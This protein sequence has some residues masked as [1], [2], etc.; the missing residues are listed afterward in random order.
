MTE[1]TGVV[2]MF[3]DPLTLMGSAVVVGQKAPPFKALND[4]LKPRGLEDYAGKVLL[5]VAVP[6]LDTQVCDMEARRF[7]AEAA[8]LGAGVTVLVISMDLP[9]AQK[10]FCAAAEADHVIMLS[11]HRD[12]SFGINWG[13]LIKDLRLL[14]RS[15]FVVD[16][17]GVVAYA[18]VVP[19]ITHEPDYAAALSVAKAL[20]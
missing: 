9:F 19:E 18:E 20:I 14:A 10:R 7:N 4:G 16:K 13:V 1:R 11:D 17:K 3:G 5:I 15:V 12:A 6:S 2:T 8:L